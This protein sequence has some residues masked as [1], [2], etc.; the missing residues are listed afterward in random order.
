MED[1][2]NWCFEV[3]WGKCVNLQ[4]TIQKDIKTANEELFFGNFL[5][6]GFFVNDNLKKAG[7]LIAKLEYLKS[8]PAPTNDPKSKI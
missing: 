7:N 4:K 1:Y 2:R 3:L 5:F 6:R 8:R